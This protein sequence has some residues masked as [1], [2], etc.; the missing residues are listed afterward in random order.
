[1]SSRSKGSSGKG[2]Q[3]RQ[4]KQKPAAAPEPKQTAG[5]RAMFEANPEE[6]AEQALQQ[7]AASPGPAAE[8][9]PEV[10]APPA[11]PARREPAAPA[12]ATAAAAP[13]VTP[14][15]A[16]A[17]ARVEPVEAVLA[18]GTRLIERDG[19]L[20]VRDRSGNDW[21]P[22]ALDKMT[23]SFTRLEAFR[24]RQYAESRRMAYVDVLRERLADIMEGEPE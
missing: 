4:G 18:D 8:A 15:P 19:K 20:L 6:V 17:V 3:K 10:A 16:P 21:P 5:W 9:E 12:R 13:A 7:Q 14:P 11:E 22:Q 23:V 24:L 2:A 1:M